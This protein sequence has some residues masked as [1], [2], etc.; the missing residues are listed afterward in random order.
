MHG[1]QGS[2]RRFDFLKQARAVQYI[3]VTQDGDRIISERGDIETEKLTRIA[4][5][6]RQAVHAVARAAQLEHD[7]RQRARDVMEAT[8]G[9]TRAIRRRE[10]P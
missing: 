10:Y 2:R 7:G 9:L 4:I 3:H 6:V 1:V 8:L 5:D